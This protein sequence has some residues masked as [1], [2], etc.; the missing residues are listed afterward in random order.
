LI[1][2]SDDWAEED[3]WSP[4]DDS[5]DADGIPADTLPCPECG[6]EIYEESE[7][8]PYCGA[9]VVFDTSVWSGRST[10]WVVLGL[11]GVVAV[12]AALVLLG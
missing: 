5:P 6:E 3:E 7:R 2:P 8:C 10:A 11:L 4:D 12:I 1:T 9:Y